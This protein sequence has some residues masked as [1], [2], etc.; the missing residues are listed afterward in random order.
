MHWF[1]V[2]HFRTQKSPWTLAAVP[3]WRKKRIWQPLPQWNAVRS[4]WLKCKNDESFSQGFACETLNPR[5]YVYAS[6]GIATEQL[7]WMSN[8][9]PEDENLQALFCCFCLSHKYGWQPYAWWSV[10]GNHDTSVIRDPAI[11]KAG[12]K[13]SGP[14]GTGGGQLFLLKE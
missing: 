4:M 2:Q 9:V 1:S 12:D 11:M 6:F 13:V 3:E 5:L 10:S 14:F 7:Q 8:T